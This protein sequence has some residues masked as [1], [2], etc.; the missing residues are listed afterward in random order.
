VSEQKSPSAATD[1]PRQ[2]PKATR[3]GEIEEDYKAQRKAPSSATQPEIEEAHK[4]QRKA[5]ASTRKGKGSETDTKESGKNEATARQTI[6]KK[7]GQ[8]PEQ[9]VNVP[10]ERTTKV[11]GQRGGKGKVQENNSGGAE[12]EEAAEKARAEKE[13][14]KRFGKASARKGKD[15]VWVQLQD[16]RNRAYKPDEIRGIQ[17]TRGKPEVGR[18]VLTDEG[19]GRVVAIGEPPYS[20][21][22]IHEPLSHEPPSKPRL[23]TNLKHNPKSASPQPTDVQELYSRSIEDVQGVRWA[24]DDKGVIHRFAAPRN[25][26][27]HWNGSTAG[28]DPIQERN[29]PPPIKDALNDRRGP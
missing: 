28:A 6:S 20:E 10:E 4:A 25:G 2:I 29:I 19:Q 3:Q 5:T 12:G 27:T 1:T 18:P 21:Q 16:G 15:T 11:A 22:V 9:K 7:A 17:G 13:A 23:V 8:P 24:K 26:E 14:A